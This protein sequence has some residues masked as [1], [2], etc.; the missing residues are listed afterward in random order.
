MI[1]KTFVCCSPFWARRGAQFE[2]E[3]RIS[4]IVFYD[5]SKIPK[6][7][8]DTTETS[9]NSNFL[10]FKEKTTVCLSILIEEVSNSLGLFKVSLK[11]GSYYQTRELLVNLTTRQVTMLD[12]TPLGQTIIWIQP[13]S[14]GDRIQYVGQGDSAVFARVKESLNE[15]TVQGVQDVYSLYIGGEEVE[16]VISSNNTL[17]NP[18]NSQ[19]IKY[20]IPRVNYYDADTFI[21]VRGTIDQDAFLSAFNIIMFSFLEEFRLVYTNVDLGPQNLFIFLF[22]SLPYIIL[23][24]TILIITTYAIFIKKLLRSK[25]KLLFF[26]LL[27]FF[28]ILPSSL[29]ATCKS[30]WIKENAR[31]DYEAYIKEISFYFFDSKLILQTLLDTPGSKIVSN[32]SLA[33][34]IVSFEDEVPSR[35]SLV[36]RE[37]KDSTGIFQVTL[38][39]GQYSSTINLQVDLETRD[40]YLLNGTYLG[41]TIFWIPPCKKGDRFPYFGQADSTVFAT[42]HDFFS[43][44][45]P[46]GVQ[47]LLLIDVSEHQYKGY[48]IGIR[49]E[50]LITPVEAQS[51]RH[52]S[53]RGNFYDADTF[54]MIE[55]DIDQDA[56]LSAFD[57]VYITPAYFKLVYTNID[58]GPQNLLG[59]L[60]G[61]LLLL[62]IPLGVIAG[63]TVYYLRFKRKRKY[64]EAQ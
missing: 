50:E 43:L 31:F 17:L 53:L 15:D 59:V 44:T 32:G 42:A 49:G 54:V 4:H 40:V 29:I 27:L 45:T 7:L 25:N 9:V 11:I 5:V 55:G 57:I 61:I 18:L 33:R 36:L 21:M 63:V 37:F 1:F 56:F 3:G 35:I 2:Y 24:T 20:F 52:F 12:G 60:T 14:L 30:A 22:K 10:F 41:K 51:I 26:T 64:G 39:I 34:V 23:V 6:E 48:Y 13:C 16:L 58:L 38:E 28:F 8:L 19:S 62:I 47:D 46:Q